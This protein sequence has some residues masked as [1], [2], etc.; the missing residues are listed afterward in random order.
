MKIPRTAALLLGLG[1]VATVVI[2]AS[3]NSN[4][5]STGITNPPV[6]ELNSGNIANGGTYQHVFAN[7]GTFNYHCTI[8]GTAMSGSVVVA[9]GAP[10]TV[11][12]AIGNNF[13]NPSTATV[14][15]N[16]TV[17]WTNNG[18]THTVTSN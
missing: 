9:N 15:P 7:L 16:G 2:V 11:S 3:C 10:A 4:N 1:L 5:N 17:T 14:G 18:V 8:H 6:R 12:V 13:Y